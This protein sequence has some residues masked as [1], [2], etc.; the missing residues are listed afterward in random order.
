MFGISLVFL[1][2]S[3]VGLSVIPIYNVNSSGNQPVYTNVTIIMP[4]EKP[5][6]P[7]SSGNIVSLL[8]ASI[9]A[10][11]LVFVALSFRA[12]AKAKQLE[13]IKKIQDEITKLETSKERQSR[14][15]Y[16][17]FAVQYLNTHNRLAYLV[18]KKILPNHLAKFYEPNFKAAY[19]LLQ[20]DEY[21][22]YVPEQQ[23]LIDWCTENNI[24]PG[25]PPQVGNEE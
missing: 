23:F 18:S 21:K 22:K 12:N 14:G 3:I 5:E 16:R 4:E 19:G 24:T 17:V 8:S 20:L 15:N 9:A 11:G 2:V 1:L 25:D 13:V 7:I 6:P 10:G